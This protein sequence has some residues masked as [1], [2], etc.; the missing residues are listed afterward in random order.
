[1]WR[2]GYSGL[3]ICIEPLKKNYQKLKSSKLESTKFI[4]CVSGN[5][6]GYV[7]INNASNS[8]LSSSILEF[9]DYYTIAAP[10]I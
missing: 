7:K 8:G 4:N 9:N 3:V 5:L 2:R 10:N 6:N 1:V